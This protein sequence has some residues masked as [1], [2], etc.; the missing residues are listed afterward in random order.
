M[1][2]RSY[3]A[4]KRPTE[5]KLIFFHQFSR[6]WFRILLG[7]LNIDRLF[8]CFLGR[9]RTLKID[10]LPP[11]GEYPVHLGAHGSDFALSLHLA[12]F[13]WLYVFQEAFQRRQNGIAA[14]DTRFL[15]DLS[16]LVRILSRNFLYSKFEPGAKVPWFYVELYTRVYL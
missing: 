11:V 16:R 7:R 6:I 3:T 4:P 13:V 2:T 5:I 1:L 8:C 15:N 12:F 14:G 10:F 9:L